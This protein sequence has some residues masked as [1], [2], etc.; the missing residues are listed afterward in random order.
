MAMALMA[1]ATL[2]CP[3]NPGHSHLPS[4]HSSKSSLS[5]EINNLCANGNPHAALQL[6][7]QQCP[8]PSH[9]TSQSHSIGFILQACGREGQLDVGRGVHQLIHSCPELTSNEIL[10]TRLLTMYSMCGSLLHSRRVFEAIEDKNLF[11]WNAL[12]SGYTRNELW[13]EILCVFSQ[14]I[15]ETELIPNNFTLPCVFKSCAGLLD[16]GMGRA[17]HGITVKMGLSSDAFVSN[18]LMSMYGKCGCV[19]DAVQ[20]FDEMPERNLVSWNTVICALSENGLV[21]ECFDF[22]RKMMIVARPDDATVV[23][24]LPVCAAEGWL[25][26]GK[27]L[28]GLSVKLELGFELKVNNALIDMYGKCGSLTEAQR[29]FDKSAE[30]NVVSWN[31]LIG[32]Y[33]MNGDVERTLCLLCAMAVEEGIRPNEITVLNVLPVCLG[34]LELLKVKELHG[35]VT[36]NG[37]QSNEMIFSGLITAYTKCGSLESAE[38]IVHNIEIKTV[39]IWN[40]LMSGYVQSG[41]PTGAMDLFHRMMSLGF[42]PDWISIS[43]LLSACTHLK[44]LSSGS[45][46]HGFILR[47]GLETDSFITISLLSLYM[48]C[49]KPLFARMLFDA[50]EEKNSVSWNTMI[51]GYAKNGLMEESLGL[52]RRMQHDN[53]EPSAIA[54]TSTLM[55]CGQISALHLGKATHCFALKADFSDDTFVSSSIIDMY[56]KCGSIEHARNFFENLN[57]REDTASWSAMITGYGIHG[58]GLEAVQLFNMMR[59]EGLR[60]DEFTYIGILMACSH[61]GLVK[62]G[63]KYFEEM[64]KIQGVEPKLEHYACVV[65]MLGRAGRLVDAARLIEE[66]PVDP[67]GRIWSSLL[68]ACKIHSDTNLGERVAKKLLELEPNKAEHYIL[69]ANLFAGSGKWDDVRR[70]REK[71]KEAGLKKEPGLSW[72]NVGN[73]VYKFVCGHTRYPES[74]DVQRLLC[75]LKEKIQKSG[76]IPD[77]SC[78]LHELKEEEKVEILQ[79]HSEK[80][81]IAFGLLKMSHGMT[82]RVFKNI[83]MCKDC[84]NTAKL[85]SKVVERQIIVRDNKRFHHFSHGICSC[86]DYW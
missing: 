50:M 57:N 54:T 27:V 49:E 56:A 80:Q 44:D 53:C 13:D 16:V 71:M 19:D 32:G 25:E 78:V 21:V 42:E 31:A 41:Q 37:L 14:L 2:Y 45:A 5:L 58:Y 51:T 34:P 17:V 83:R 62:E 65:D 43:S 30:R 28:H 7:L 66:M 4:F 73:K 26:M 29:L 82:L 59:R 9:L 24:L 35:Y 86:G 70:M 81:A 36:R 38:R 3:P 77:T 61:V 79:R 72:I 63:L 75:E 18:S 11:H 10:T 67:D 33:S 47:H 23:T 74:E 68:G 48:Q 39:S 76:Y 85:V 12:I 20:V 15:S 55:V 52:Y 64:R 6:L 40:A 84:H 8:D 60:P 69:A 22:F 46:V 1:N